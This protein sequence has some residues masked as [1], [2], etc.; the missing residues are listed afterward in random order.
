MT[1]KAVLLPWVHIYAQAFTH[2]NAWM[3]SNIHAHKSNGFWMLSVLM[4]VR[5]LGCHRTKTM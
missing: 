5:K 3:Y 4:E 2:M 1:A